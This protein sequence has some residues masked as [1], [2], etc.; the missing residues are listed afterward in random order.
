M[1]DDMT[2]GQNMSILND[3]AIKALVKLAKGSKHVYRVNVNLDEG[4][5]FS[6]KEYGL[7]ISRILNGEVGKN[8]YEMVEEALFDSDFTLEPGHVACL[9]FVESGEWEDNSWNRYY[10]L[11]GLAEPVISYDEITMRGDGYEY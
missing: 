2:N 5:T 10:K 4:C 7:A 6:E 11:A 8:D 9:I 1:S 3:S